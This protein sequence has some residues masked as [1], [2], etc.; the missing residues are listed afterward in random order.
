MRSW[1]LQPWRYLEPNWTWPWATCSMWLWTGVHASLSHSVIPWSGARAQLVLPMLWRQESLLSLKSE[2]HNTHGSAYQGVSS[3]S[4]SAKQQHRH[5]SCLPVSSFPHGFLLAKGKGEGNVASHPS[6]VLDA[7]AC[8]RMHWEMHQQ[9]HSFT[10]SY[11]IAMLPFISSS[12]TQ[13]V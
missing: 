13:T 9:W 7:G 1:C 5:I 8:S 2:G 6:C 4:T 11:S 3:S 12:E 10:S